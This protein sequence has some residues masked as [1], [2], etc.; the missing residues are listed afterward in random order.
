MK[1]R[2]TRNVTLDKRRH[3]ETTSGLGFSFILDGNE[4]QN[5]SSVN[6][7][8]QAGRYL[9]Q[10]SFLFLL[11]FVSVFFQTLWEGEEG[12]GGRDG[13]NWLTFLKHYCHREERV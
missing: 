4:K 8:P 9:R 6:K 3:R 1:P 12:L 2:S 5:H 7:P 10:F 11:A 13:Q